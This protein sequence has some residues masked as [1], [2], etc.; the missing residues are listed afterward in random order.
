[1]EIATSGAMTEVTDPHDGF[2][3]LVLQ[4]TALLQRPP[5]AFTV[6]GAWDTA[7]K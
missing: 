6:M 5:W 1:M 7:M 2:R 4:T 3:V